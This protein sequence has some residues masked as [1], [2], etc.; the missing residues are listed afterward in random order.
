MGD[1]S[2]N[3]NRAEFA[4]KCGCGFDTVD[5]KLIDYVQQ[6]REHFAVP[7]TINSSCRCQEHNHAVGGR[8]NSQHKR[9]RAADIVVKGVA[10][11]KVYDYAVKIGCAGGGNYNSFTHIDSRTKSG[12][13]W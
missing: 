13:R 12:A 11:Q 8:P 3:F 6:I 7:I 4:C 2:A 5:A 9:G 10:P 1:L